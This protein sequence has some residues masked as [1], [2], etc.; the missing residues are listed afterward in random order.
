MEIIFDKIGLYLAVIITIFCL[1]SILFGAPLVNTNHYA[2]VKLFDEIKKI[3][4]DK[5][6]RSK[7]K[8]IDLGAGTGKL[9]QYL[10]SMGYQAEGYEINPWFFI[11]A[12]LYAR[13]VKFGNFL[14]KNLESYDIIYIFSAKPYLAKNSQKLNHCQATIISYGFPLE[15]PNHN[16]MKKSGGFFI[17]QSK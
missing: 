11:I 17:Y 12:K 9:V 14:K 8:I 7:I 5:S 3:T 13:P 6:D 16:L 2:L 4:G 10:N 15:L 1:P